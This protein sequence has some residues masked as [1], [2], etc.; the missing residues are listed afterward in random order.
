MH[1]KTEDVLEEI[2]LIV[3]VWCKWKGI[4]DILV[5]AIFLQAAA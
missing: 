5:L 3:M 2:V 1:H 4:T